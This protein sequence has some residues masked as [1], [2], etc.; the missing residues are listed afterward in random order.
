MTVAG[1]LSATVSVATACKALSLPRASFY[2]HQCPNP[3][4]PPKPRPIPARALPTE[5]RSAVLK[6]LHDP[7]FIDLSPSEVYATLLDEKKYICSV[8]TMYRI[9]DSEHEVRERRNILRHP[10]YPKPELVATGPNQIWSWDITKLHGPVKWMYFSLYVV[11]DIFSRY[12][13]GWLVA[14]VESKALAHRLIEAS[15]LKQGIIDG[16]LVI[17]SDRGGPMKSKPVAQL[18]AELGVTRSLSRPHVSN[19]N[20]FSEAQFK[21]LKYAPSFPGR[22]GS[23]EDA[24]QFCK[25]F[26]TWYNTEHR[27]SGIGFLTPQSVHHGLAAQLIEQR[28]L[29]LEQ[30]YAANP[31][32]FVRGKPRPPQLPPAVWIN[33]PKAANTSTAPDPSPIGSESTSPVAPGALPATQARVQVPP[34]SRSLP[35]RLS[36]RRCSPTN[37]SNTKLDVH[38]SQYA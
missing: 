10:K 36:M 13:V 18:L 27:H 19:D 11:L 30:A 21:T 16:Q 8:R 37:R 12:V 20:P 35:T 32:R 33:P 25:R 17:H 9:L 7:R 4:A 6:V 5:E 29:V 38:L 23:L 3:K 1:E 28:Q 34:L 24:R 2:R 26:F 22:F 31:E 15:C 14:P